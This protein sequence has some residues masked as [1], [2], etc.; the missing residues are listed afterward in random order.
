M[1][2]SIY[3][4]VLSLFFLSSFVAPVFGQWAEVK[5]PS[6]FSPS[7]YYYAGSVTYA[8]TDLT[9]QKFLSSSDGIH[10][11]EIDLS[12]ASTP[13]ASFFSLNTNFYAIGDTILMLGQSGISNESTY[14]STD[15]G[16]TWFSRVIQVPNVSNINNSALFCNANRFFISNGNGLY[17][18][19]DLGNSYTKHQTFNTGNVIILECNHNVLF[20]SQ[21]GSSNYRSYDNG[22]T[23]HLLS[24]PAG[25]STTNYSFL[26]CID[27]FLYL[28][29][30]TPNG[31]VWY[32][33]PSNGNQWE[34]LPQMPAYFSGFFFKINQTFYLTIYSGGSYSTFTSTD[35]CQTWNE[36]FPGQVINKIHDQV[37]YNLS[38]NSP[39]YDL[40][41]SNQGI[42]WKPGWIGLPS[43]RYSIATTPEGLHIAGT[44][45][46]V[47]QY[48]DQF[49][50]TEWSAQSL[51]QVYFLDA[52]S[53]QNMLASFASNVLNYSLDGG[54]TF[55]QKQTSIGQ[56][57]YL[58][59]AFN[60]M[61]FFYDQL[62]NIFTSSD[63]GSTLQPFTILGIEVYG[64][65]KSNTHLCLSAADGNI[66]IADR[67]NPLSFQ[68]I[69]PPNSSSIAGIFGAGDF[70]FYHTFDNELFR[71]EGSG[72]VACQIPPFT[73][74]GYPQ[75]IGNSSE[76]IFHNYNGF[77]GQQLFSSS[78]GGLN[79]INISAEVPDNISSGK[80]GMT[81]TH[82][83]FAVVKDNS[84][85]ETAL[86]SKP[87]T[88][89][90]LPSAIGSVFH[91]ENQNGTREA[92]EPAAEGIIL[93]S[94]KYGFFAVSDTA[95]AFSIKYANTPNDTIRTILQ[96]KYHFVTTP[97]AIA[98]P[99]QTNPLSIGIA[100]EANKRDLCV[101]LSNDIVFRPGFET[102]L[103]ATVTNVGTIAAGGELSVTLPSNLTVM[104]S[105][106]TASSQLGDTYFFTI[107]DLQVGQTMQVIITVKTSI[108]TTIGTQLTMTAQIDP[109]ATDEDPFNNT[110]TL[111][112]EVVG[113]YDPNDKAVS[114]AN[115]TPDQAANRETMYYT[116]RF[117]NTGNF[118]A[119]YVRILD[120]L[121]QR[122]D[123]ET[124]QVV[125]ASH[126]YSWTLHERNILDVF[127]DNINLLDSFANEPAS[128]GFV[129]FSIKPKAGMQLGQSISNT[130]HI[131]F[132]FN[133]AVVT[134]TVKSSV[135]VRTQEP[136]NE[137][138]TFSVSPNLGVGPY[139]VTLDEPINE[140]AQVQ[141]FDASGRMCTEASFERLSVQFVLPAFEA[142]AGVYLVQ[143]STKTGKVSRKLV[144]R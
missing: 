102:R 101:A 115:L 50:N 144:V 24:L 5:I 113:S 109:I 14:Y 8:Q 131:Y 100:T 142:S 141:V 134:N 12:F 42:S 31:I 90:T 84:I 38:F 136:V 62:N 46:N 81:N 120:T 58:F 93:K 59:A 123:V 41:S 71:F 37:M 63:F 22:T 82:F 130:A 78:N 21:S 19:D 77:L 95:G 99:N 72:L 18:S 108:P 60:G 65:Y 89:S 64:L 94:A 70:L 48:F 114:P 34:P 117:Q 124:I 98:D 116:I 125:A 20:A 129:K 10:F 138:F 107:P 11:E 61:L 88:N 128:H 51:N 6:D 25:V 74:L 15:R 40:I 106:P 13:F 44:N 91:D 97:S 29:V 39:N 7:S 47:F 57:H 3:H 83:Y 143:L 92:T 56:D 33:L 43:S 127:F 67:S 104:S 111:R 54:R 86:Y 75:G 17:F 80:L 27:D 121:D 45:A 53:D 36:A 105:I 140:P 2:T 68:R 135:T 87:T 112:E 32:R 132:D 133:A 118:P 126:D 49:Q 16:A 55:T 79:W 23:W 1:R 139:T 76:L 69:T 103:Y 30:S 119:T 9:S 122:L 66:F 96:N 137:P 110:N 26:D 52:V 73:N 35:D 28:S 4:F 85:F